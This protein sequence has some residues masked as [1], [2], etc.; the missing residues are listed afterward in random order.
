MAVT[1]WD[2]RFFETTKGRV[3]ALLRR[4]S[5]TIDELAAALGVTDNA[6]RTHVAALER[7]GIVQQR[8]V[9]PTGGKPAYSYEVVP[10]A[11]RVFT[12]AYIPVLTQLVGVL[13]ERMSPEEMEALLREVGR[14]LAGGPRSGDARARADA[15]A[16]VLTELGGVVDV[17]TSGDALTL[18]GFSCPLA[19]AVRA[20][21]ATCQAVESM[22]AELVG[23]PVRE[24]CDRGARP[25][26]CF[27][28]L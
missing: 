27:E 3:L 24:Q 12:K 14:R 20:H 11:E 17:E 21:P 10:E 19:D 25:R 6:V 1:R 8:G 4:G 2:S 5:R 18:R 26:C 23:R 28:V 13:A 9:R 15:A 22:V 16:T 7:D